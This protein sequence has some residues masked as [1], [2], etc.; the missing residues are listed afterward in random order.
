MDKQ[1]DIMPYLNLKL[2]APAAAGAVA[3]LAARLAT[4]TT[5]VLGKKHGVTAVAVEHAPFTRWFIGGR[6]LSA[7][8]ASFFLE[9]KVTEGTNTKDE[10]AAFLRGAYAA[11]EEVLGPVDP[12]SYIVIQEVRADAWGYAGAT[13]EQRYIESRAAAAGARDSQPSRLHAL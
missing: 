3:E 7:G 4:L 8:V 11:A 5:E 12:A 2:A 1:G 10:K 13:Q 9:V 6:P